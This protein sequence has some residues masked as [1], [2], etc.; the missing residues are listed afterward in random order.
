M[1][2]FNLKYII[3]KANPNT[4]SDEA[5]VKKTIAIICPKRSSKKIEKTIKFIFIANNI[6]SILINVKIKYLFINIVPKNPI[7][8][9]I[10]VNI[11]YIYIKKFYITFF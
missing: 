7:K 11:K 5:S 10:K 2:S 6:N 9:N 3:T 1:P 8:N 4:L